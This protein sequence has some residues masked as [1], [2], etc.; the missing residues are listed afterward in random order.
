MFE[1]KAFDEL[2]RL[3][4]TANSE[5][6]ARTFFPSQTGM[7][8]VEQVI[9]GSPAAGKLSPGDIL[10]RINGELVT[11]F[12]PLAALLDDN[13]GGTVEVEIE[14]GGASVVEEIEVTD[15]HN[16]TPDEFLEFGD[17]IVN[18][19][20]YQQARHYNREVTGAYVANPGY[21]LSKAAIREA[22]SLSKL[23]A[24][25]SPGSMIWKRHSTRCRTA[26]ARKFA[27]SPWTT[28]KIPSSGCSR[29]IACGSQRGVARATTQ[30]AC[31]HAG[32][33]VQGRRLNPPKSAA[34]A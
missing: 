34:R 33:S 30:R 5:R 16:I 27:T 3:G 26:A 15:L 29:W 17:A 4:L 6:L 22:P 7:L 23:M 10:L 25:R 8:T 32:A 11:E 12:V 24:R 18:N 20:S 19:L 14:R 2:K 31:G 28:S 9:P 21:L 13:V 1:R